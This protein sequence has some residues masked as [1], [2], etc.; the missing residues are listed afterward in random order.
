MGEAWAAAFLRARG[1]T[2]LG[3][4]VRLG[5]GEVDVISRSGAH[6]YFVEVRARSGCACGDALGSVTSRKRL[7]ILSAIQA[8][9]TQEAPDAVPHIGVLAIDGASGHRAARFLPDAF[10]APA[11]A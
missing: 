5:G 1:H 8:W 2:I 11:A 10:D 6:V 4:R 9:M 7:R 3:Q